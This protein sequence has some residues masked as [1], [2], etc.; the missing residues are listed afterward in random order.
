MKRV[1]DKGLG[2][3]K[4]CAQLKEDIFM[5]VLAIN[6]SPHKEGNTH[7]ALKTVTDNLNKEGIE[8]EILHIGNG[9]IMGCQGCGACAKTGVCAIR[10][11]AFNEWT[12]KMYDADGLIIGSPVY[13]AAINGTL[14]CFLDRAFYSGRGKMRQK[15]GA[16]LAVC[17]RSGGMTAFEQINAYFYISD[18]FIAPSTYWNIGHGAKAGEFLQDV[19]A[20]NTLEVLAKNMVW[21]LKMKEETKDSIA[22]PALEG[23]NAWMN[24]IRS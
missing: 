8:T 3:Q 11:E 21:F 6:G 1:K 20:V 14:K 18:M 9:P 24:F 4:L 23:K 5:K 17:R 22:A 12:Q 10:D 2:A 13:Y 7:F 16:G 19:E 15:V